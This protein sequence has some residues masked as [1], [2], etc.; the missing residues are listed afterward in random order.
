MDERQQELVTEFC[1]VTG[2]SPA[3]AQT[4]LASANWN[5]A[6]AVSLFFAASEEPE[7]DDQDMEDEASPAQPTPAQPSQPS[8]SSSSKNAGKRPKQMTID[9]L[10]KRE[11]GDD[12]ESDDEQKK[13]NMFAGG[14]KSGLAVQNPNQGGGPPDHFKNIM[15]KARQNHDRP[16]KPNEEAQPA[17][18]SNFTGRAQTLGGDDAPSQVVED[19]NAAQRQRQQSLPRVTRT[20]HLWADGVSIDDGPLFRFDDPANQAIMDQINQGRAPLALLDV[21]PGQEVDLNL[22]PH[23]DENYVAP[24]KTYKPF[25]G[26]GQR[27]GSPTPGPNPSSS[28]ATTQPAAAPATSSSTTTTPQS[29]NVDDSQPTIQL[30]IRL[31]DGTRLS[32]RFNTTHT[33]GDV[34]AFVSAASPES[35]QRAFA[36]M[37]TFPS[38]ELEDRSVVLGDMADFK[39]GGVVVQKWT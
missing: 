33:V 17:D 19:P 2:A 27:L 30:Q 9:D 36:L 10:K 37:T 26:S 28:S 22:D 13:Q 35:Q 31:G 16:K 39:R 34:Y 5:L 25:G 12:D 4:A 7:D 14:E 8:A 18:P 15:N 24:K 3:S 21:Q 32:S 38:K 1:G 6:E 20:M 29:V 11:E 23:K